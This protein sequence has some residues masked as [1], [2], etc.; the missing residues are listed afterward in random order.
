MTLMVI[1]VGCDPRGGD[2]IA[3]LVRAY[4]PDAVIGLDPGVL[5]RKYR[6]GKA[7]V[8]TWGAAAWTFTGA[9]PFRQTGR[10]GFGRVSEDGEPVRC[11]DLAEIVLGHE[12]DVVLKIDAEGA[13]WTLL[14][15]LIATGASGRLR[16]CW[17]EW[18][19]PQ[20]EH[21]DGH[22]E[23]CLVDYTEAR[24]DLERRMGCV[25]HE[26]NR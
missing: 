17:V 25:M 16:E 12:G 10:F 7:R 19:C 5:D 1:D 23:G 20:C 6:R 8:Q 9:L 22:L 4:K 24:M 13:E 2:S 3:H 11:V 26:W 15:H 21:G 18:H 14:P